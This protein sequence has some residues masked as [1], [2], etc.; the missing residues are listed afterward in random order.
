MGD[1][2]VGKITSDTGEVVVVQLR[3]SGAFRD[4]SVVLSIVQ[5]GQSSISA[6]N[7]R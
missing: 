7:A 5:I 4:A 6:D 2:C 1:L 3:R